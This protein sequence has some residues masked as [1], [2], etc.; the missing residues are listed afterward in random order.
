MN[1]SD[2]N[3]RESHKKVNKD[4]WY[5]QIISL[6]QDNVNKNGLTAREVSQKLF[7]K[8]FTQNAERQS[9]APRLSEL[10]EKGVVKVIGKKKDE[11]TNRN[12][13]IY[14]LAN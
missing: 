8:G 7:T 3:R 14:A 1:I 10:T 9:A 11:I 2:D 12:V 5:S 6:L 13:G 4:V